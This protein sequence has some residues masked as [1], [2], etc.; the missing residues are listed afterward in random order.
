MG[1]WVLTRRINVVVFCVFA[2]LVRITKLEI[3]SVSRFSP[4]NKMV[5]GRKVT[6]LYEVEQYLGKSREI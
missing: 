1:A 2:H 4:Y 5:L 3:L 6:L